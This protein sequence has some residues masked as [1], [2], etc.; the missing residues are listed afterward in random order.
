[1]A[2]ANPLRPASGA[3]GD[4]A[5]LIGFDT[6]QTAVRLYWRAL[7]PA[8]ENYT[9]FVHALDAGDHILAQNDAPPAGGARPT[10]G[11]AAGETIA[12]DHPLVLPAGATALAVGLYDSSTG[13]RVPVKNGGD[14]LILRLS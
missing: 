8:P 9:V 13:Q 1:S 12:D 3:L 5:E 4:F 6:T 10:R 2:A 11:W 14:R 7:G